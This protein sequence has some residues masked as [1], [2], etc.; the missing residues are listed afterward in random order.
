MHQTETEMPGR[1]GD[2]QR[3]CPD[4]AR[5][6]QLLGWEPRIGFVEGLEKTIVDFQSRLAHRPHVLVFSTAYLP[7]KGPA[8]EATSEV[9]ARLPGYEFDIIT[10]RFDT[11][12]TAET[13]AGRVHIYRL[14][15]GTA[16]DKF[17]LPFRAVVK[18]RQLNKT[19]RYQVAWAIMASYGAL[20]AA[21]FSLLM[22]RRV[23]FLLSVFEGDIEEKMLTRG[24]MLAPMY[25]LIF[26]RANRWQV[27]GKMSEMQRLWL[28][29]ERKVQA[30]PE[31]GNFD[32]L[33]KRTKEMFQELEILSTR[34]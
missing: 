26:Q 31:N 10:A 2:P 8:E 18:A 21:F 1:V 17:L 7:M 32:L 13:H 11:K 5:A 28:E 33:A 16:L 30:I 14:G 25:R 24:K 22:R 9:I 6:K 34:L 29:D 12:V 23:P 20:A 27:I 15:Q 4:I 19:H 3:R